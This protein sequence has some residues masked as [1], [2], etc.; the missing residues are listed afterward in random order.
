MN[1]G[2][3]VGVM[4]LVQSA[5]AGSQYNYA[6]MLSSKPAQRAKDPEQVVCVEMGKGPNAATCLAAATLIAVP[7]GGGQVAGLI[8]V[9]RIIGGS[10]IAYATHDF[11]KK[12]HIVP[13]TVLATRAVRYFSNTMKRSGSEV[14]PFDQWRDDFLKA[15]NVP[16]DVIEKIDEDAEYGEFVDPWS[17]GPALVDP[18]HEAIREIEE[19]LGKN[20]LTPEEKEEIIRRANVGQPLADD[21]EMDDREESTH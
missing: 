20:F 19:H 17:F 11:L 6:I 7:S 3:L 8:I 12:V 1:R 21:E 4:L 15:R 9:G 2:I 5:L 18:G 13:P 14:A 16:E 10:L